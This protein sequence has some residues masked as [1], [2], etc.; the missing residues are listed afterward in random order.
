MLVADGHDRQAITLA[1]QDHIL[2]ARLRLELGERDRAL[3]FFYKSD[4]HELPA[5]II[6]AAFR[7]EVV[8][9]RIELGGIQIGRASCRERV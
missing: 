5:R 6:G 1:N 8:G 2:K 9:F 7:V 3:E 4:I